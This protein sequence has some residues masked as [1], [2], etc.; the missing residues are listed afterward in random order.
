MVTIKEIAQW[1]DLSIG[2]VDRVLHGRGRVSK[3]TEDKVK[4]IIKRTGYKTNIYARNLSLQT[5]HHIGV[6]M[7]NP[8]PKSN[9][10][11]MLQRGID[12]A[13]DELRS[14]KIK[15]DYFFF[16]KFSESSFAEAGK[17]DSENLLKKK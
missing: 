10:W 2:T 12:R 8:A 1:A 7:P 9:Y 3:K 13:V 16:N 15:V 11:S 5:T 6:I 14:F 17:E 4:A